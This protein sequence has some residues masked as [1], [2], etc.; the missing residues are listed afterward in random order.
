MTLEE[1]GEKALEW[2]RKN[3]CILEIHNGEVICSEH[4]FAWD[5]ELPFCN[6]FRGDEATES[7][8]NILYMLGI[9]YKLNKDGE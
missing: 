7:A 4:D 5:G 1:V 9:A 8:L 6:S 3:K 2:I